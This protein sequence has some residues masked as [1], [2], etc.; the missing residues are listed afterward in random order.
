MHVLSILAGNSHLQ[1]PPKISSHL[2]LLFEGS[3]APNLAERWVIGWWYIYTGLALQE[4]YT[5]VSKP[6]V[7]LPFQ[8][9][10]HFKFFPFIGQGVHMTVMFQNVLPPLALFSLHYMVHMMTQNTGM[11]SR[12]HM[13]WNQMDPYGST[14]PSRPGSTSC[15]AADIALP[16]VVLAGLT[17]KNKGF[18]V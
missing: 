12:K 3:R 5:N 6:E 15:H 9:G 8:Q 14:R 1:V 11:E 4:G 7:I 18:L 17:E 13:V 10:S 16:S 2:F